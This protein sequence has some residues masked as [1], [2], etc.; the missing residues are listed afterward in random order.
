MAKLLE[1]ECPSVLRHLSAFPTLWGHLL[2]SQPV[3]A[4][5]Y[6]YHCSCFH[7]FF[8]NTYPYVMCYPMLGSWGDL[9]PNREGSV[10]SLRHMP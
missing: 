5:I 6:I 2:K 10:C 8:T 3:Q 4:N 1:T 7:K 9:A